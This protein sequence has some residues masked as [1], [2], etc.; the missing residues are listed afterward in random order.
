M[1]RPLE[2]KKDLDRAAEIWLAEIIRVYNF[3]PEPDK[4]WGKRLDEMKKVTRR[5]EGYVY[6]EDGVIKAFVTLKDNYIWD[7]IVDSKY[8]KNGIGSELLD[9]IKELKPSLALGIFE[10]HQE[11]IKFFEKRGFS[12]ANA[13]TSPEGYTK[14]EM[15]WRK[16]G[17]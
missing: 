8:Q 3:V 4:Y 16:E 5:A 7:L 1:I 2:P 14:F 17:T 13:Y 12:K 9:F 15:I 11:A 6:E 10:E